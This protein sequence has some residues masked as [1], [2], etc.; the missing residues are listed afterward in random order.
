MLMFD[1]AIYKERR[2]ALVKKMQE[3]GATGIAVFLGNV[4]APM[5]YRDNCFEFRQDSTFLY[6]WGLNE[7]GLAASINLENGRE[8][9]Y[10]DDVDIDDIIWMGPQPALSEKAETVG[11]GHTAA[12][13]DFATAVQFALQNDVPVH[14]LPSGRWANRLKMSE[15]TGT[16]SATVYN[17]APYDEG[18]DVHSSLELTKAVIAMR[19]VK[20]QCEI[21][22]IDKACD[23]GV[24]MHTIGRE[25]CR[26]G[27]IEKDIAGAMDGFAITKGWGVSF[28]TIL[29]QNG[30]ILHGHDHSQTI[31]DGRLL[32]IDAGLALNNGYCSDF[33]RTLPCGGKFTQQQREIYDIVAD[34]NEL[35]YT[36][37]APGVAYL[38]VHKAVAKLMLE[39]LKALD[40][41]NGDVDEMTEEGIAGMFMPHGLGHN[42][43]LDV[44]DMED[45][46][47][48][49]VGYD[50]DQVRAA[51]LGLG[52]LRMAR[53]LKPGNVITDEPGIYFIPALIEQWK[54]EGKFKD[55]INYS[56]LES[57]YDFG[58]IRLEDDV[59]ITPD[60]AR[61]LGAN[62]LPIAPDD[63][64]KAMS[65][66]RK[67]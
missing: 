10:G 44:H 30:Q 45:L 55:F 23:L 61:R 31:T 32:L 53:S 52:S 66:D 40:L 5:N 22:Q 13:K 63:V 47:E 38:D 35:A 60:G 14:F 4:D 1:A 41:V 7:A 20:E 46:G 9:I 25:G 24:L 15:I 65:E 62:R 29:S 34:C 42:M 37:A 17:T 36:L 6:F 58:G 49:Y 3:Q 28:P 50:D 67:Q 59:L 64:E 33:T 48:N 27:A 57:Y 12:A 16:P 2:K 51:Q 56:K 54:G 8:C 26:P 11:V 21:E 18:D 19:L 39:R 43:G